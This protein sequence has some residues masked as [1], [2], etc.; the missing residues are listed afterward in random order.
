MGVASKHPLHSVADDLSK[1]GVVDTG[2]TMVRD[3][4]VPT[5]VRPEVQAVASSVGFQTST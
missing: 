5:L 2:G 3:V 4:V 1:V